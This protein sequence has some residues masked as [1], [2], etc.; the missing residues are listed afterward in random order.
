M[1]GRPARAPGAAAHHHALPG[2]AHADGSEEPQRAAGVSRPCGHPPPRAPS[3]PRGGECPVPTRPAT[4][5]AVAGRLQD[6]PRPRTRPRASSSAD[7]DQG[8]STR[9]ASRMLSQPARST[10]CAGSPTPRGPEKRAY[11]SARKVAIMNRLGS[12]STSRTPVAVSPP[13]PRKRSRSSSHTTHLVNDAACER[14]SCADA[15]DEGST[16]R[17]LGSRA[18]TVSY[19]ALVFPAVDSP[20]IRTN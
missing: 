19:A 10:S 4:R 18:R 13:V 7:H 14:A 17:C 11:S 8:R 20:T 1:P 6:T 3:P 16:K 9:L 12:A 2:T 5:P 15:P